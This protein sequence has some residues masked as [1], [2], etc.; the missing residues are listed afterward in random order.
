MSA[1]LVVV[2]F[3]DMFYQMGIGQALIQKKSITKQHIQTSFTVNIVVGVIVFFL[4]YLI[5]PMISEFFQEE[6]L[7]KVIHILAFVFI[8]HSFS[9][10]SEALLQRDMQFKFIS[11]FQIM[12]YILGYSCFSIGLALFGL[13]VWA[14]V[15]G[16]IMQ[17][18]IKMILVLK[19]MKQIPKIRFYFD[20]FKDLIKTGFGF[21]SGKAVNYIALQGDYVVT[22]R[23][24]GSRQLGLYNR[25]YSLMNMPVQI[26]GQAFDYVMFPILS[27]LQEEK[28]KSQELFTKSFHLFSWIIPIISGLIFVYSEFLISTVLGEKWIEITIPVQIFAFT[29]YFR[30]V[31]KICES[32]ICAKGALYRRTFIMMVYAFNIVVMSYIGSNWGIIGVSIGVSFS[33]LVH[34][35]LLSKLSIQLLGIKLTQYMGSQLVGMLFGFSL[36]ILNYFIYHMI[37]LNVTNE[38]MAFFIS[39]VVYLITLLLGITI[40][41]KTKLKQ[42]FLLIDEYTILF[43]KKINL[44]KKFFFW[45]N[46][47]DKKGIC[48]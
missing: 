16:T 34:F 32:L 18:I 41:R 21:M 46:K 44:D 14:M 42:Q 5:A 13:G 12:S 2:N 15:I 28:E 1:A 43:L 19:H 24:L 45:F 31:Y 25:T 10:T 20:A 8:I 4:L 23:L 17:A 9:M 48:K 39:I 22:G 40:V 6:Q 29:I 38:L 35:I 7:I 37:K 27:R 26:F 47:L 3:A 36:G 11:K 30:T 33:I